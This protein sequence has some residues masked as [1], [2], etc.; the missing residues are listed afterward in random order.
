[1][2]QPESTTHA[3]VVR[4]WLEDSAGAPGRGTWRGHVTH[5]MSGD[6]RYLRSLEGLS[7]YLLPYLE[8]MGARIELYWRLRRWL[9]WQT[10]SATR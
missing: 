8:A 1:M 7:L 9:Q 3:F 10:R 4:I 5:V 6:R 2:D